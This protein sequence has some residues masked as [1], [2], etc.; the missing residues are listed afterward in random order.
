MLNPEKALEELFR[1]AF[2]GY[3]QVSTLL[4][5]KVILAA[6][7]SDKAPVTRINAVVIF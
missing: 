6:R 4:N 1:H 3:S 2:A 7:T 5:P